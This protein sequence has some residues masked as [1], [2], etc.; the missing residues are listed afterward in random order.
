MDV[1]KKEDLDS[2]IDMNSK[3]FSKLQCERDLRRAI[4]VG[5]K[6]RKKSKKEKVGTQ[7][8]LS[9]QKEKKETGWGTSVRDGVKCPDSNVTRIQGDSTSPA[10]G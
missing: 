4:K 9:S 8:D 6:F 10:E 2:N 7:G 1:K 5:I 3:G